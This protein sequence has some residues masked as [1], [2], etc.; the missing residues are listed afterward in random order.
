MNGAQLHLAINHIPVFVTIT[1]ALVLLYGLLKK[2]SQVTDT[3]LMIIF[4]AG[5]FTI[6]VFLSG[7][8]AEEVAEDLAGVSRPLIEA[9]E[10]FAR[11]AL[12]SM[13]IT[14]A[15]SLSALFFRKRASLAKG[16]TFTA[17]LLSMVS[18][19]IASYTAHSGGEIRHPEIRQG[20]DVLTPDEAENM[21]EGEGPKR[22]RK[23]R[24]INDGAQRPA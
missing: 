2:R 19:G 4:A 22:K 11:I 10:A 24:A 6:P 12:W 17:L 15:M 1:G 7:E 14:A 3:G 13:V 8:A 9:H 21:N 20:G 5:I 16:L 23:G 18:F